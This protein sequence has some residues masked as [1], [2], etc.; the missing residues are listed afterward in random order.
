[1]KRS[2]ILLPFLAATCAA[3]AA[4]AVESSPPYQSLLHAVVQ[5]DVSTVK[6]LLDEGLDA[7]ARVHSEAENAILVDADRPPDQPLLVVAA[8]FGAPDALIVAALLEHRA[9]VDARDS[10]GRTP[11]MYATELGW[12]PSIS[13]LLARK[14]DVNAADARGKTVLMYSLGNRNLPTVARLL[15]RDARINATDLEGKTALI[16][17]VRDCRHDPLRLYD[18]LGGY[19]RRREDAA[20]ATARYV[21]LVRY[22]IDHKASVNQRDHYGQTALTFARSAGSPEMVKLLKD[23]GATE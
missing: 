8:R 2:L 23:A 16:Y 18:G 7:N 9:S 5:N 1:M 19:G 10:K 15:D 22:L 12:E 11:L 3:S 20:A 4:P 21:E 6:R 14:A 13:Q 17:A